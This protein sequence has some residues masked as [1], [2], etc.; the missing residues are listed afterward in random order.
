MLGD[1]C[2]VFYMYSSV[3]SLIYIYIYLHE[4]FCNTLSIIFPLPNID[5]FIFPSTTISRKYNLRSARR[6]WHLKLSQETEI[7]SY[8]TYLFTGQPEKKKNEINKFYAIKFKEAQQRKHEKN[9]LRNHSVY[10][11]EEKLIKIV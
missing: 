6:L 1:L 11:D 7:L 3:S 10:E 2:S 4:K 5:I 8:F 9:P